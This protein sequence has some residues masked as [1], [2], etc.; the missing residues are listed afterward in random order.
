MSYLSYEI[1]QWLGKPI[2]C[3]KFQCGNNFYYY[4]SSSRDYTLG[5]FSY[6]KT[7]ISRGSYETSQDTLKADID[8]K[9]AKTADVVALYIPSP[10]ENVVNLTLYRIHKGD[11][12]A[13]VYWK[14]R[15]TSCSVSGREATLKGES[16]FTMLKRMG[17]KTHY[18]IPCPHTLYDS[19]CTIVKSDYAVRSSGVLDIGGA[20]LSH[21]DLASK[22]DGWWNGGWA[23]LDTGEKRMIIA[24]TS[25]TITLNYQFVD[26]PTTGAYVTF[27]PGCDS[28]IATCNSKFNNILNFG[29][30]PYIPTDN[31][32]TGDKVM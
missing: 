2:E 25:S 21:S 22:E 30:F 6:L 15:I 12:E 27:Y 8:I 7:A 4:T 20:Q 16:V 19:H 28:L 14:G 10:P 32:F 29:G 3:F 9:I 17:L 1:E 24:H 31:L 26:F 18:Q 5:G 13:I 23:E 11:T